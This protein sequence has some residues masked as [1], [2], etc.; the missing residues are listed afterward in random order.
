MTIWRILEIEPTEN[1][2]VIKKAYAKKLKIHHPEDDP[3]GYQRLREAYDRAVKYA[4]SQLT[5]S[6]FI[7]QADEAEDELS[8]TF[9][10]RVNL[11]NNDESSAPFVHP[12]DA[13]MEEV[14]ELYDDFFSRIETDN[15]MTLLNADVVWNVELNETLQSRL[16]YFL[17]H[18]H[19]LPLPIWQLLE[20]MFHWRDQ[21]EHLRS[22]YDEDFIEYVLEQING[23]KTLQ[24]H[25]F[26]KIDGFNYDSFLKLREQAQNAMIIDELDEAKKYIDDAYQLYPDD[27]DLLRIQGEYY[28]RTH[29]LELALQSFSHAL[30]IHPNELDAR[31]YRARI[32]YDLNQYTEAIKDCEQALSL[33]PGDADVLFL[34]GKCYIK[35]GNL[36]KARN[37]FTLT[38]ET[39]HIKTQAFIYHNKISNPIISKIKPKL[40]LSRRFNLSF[41]LPMFLKR[42]WVYILLYFV[43][44]IFFDP[45][46]PMVVSF[47]L[48][49]IIWE[50]WRSHRT[51]VIRF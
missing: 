10:T 36:E 13:F 14:K 50:L 5:Q 7:E 11:I 8:S 29:H 51:F 1:M 47:I 40:S 49:P 9:L 33:V 15:W 19:Y 42:T 27:P 46:S 39:D 23:S 32:H 25:F 45:L 30:D 21:E 6:Q 26:R 18:H 22:Q 4:K 28:L 16:I 31:I 38:F 35:L 12:L 3:E 17:Y 34:L 37:L 43:L 48:I 2:S 41:L 44:E 24:Y 20:S